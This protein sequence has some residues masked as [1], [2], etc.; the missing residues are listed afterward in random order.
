MTP[1]ELRGPT[2]EFSRR[3]VLED[4]SSAK[5]ADLTRTTDGGC[6]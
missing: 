1:M 5:C 6:D 2:A 4:T 3:R